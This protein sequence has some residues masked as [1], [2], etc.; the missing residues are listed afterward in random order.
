A[1]LVSLDRLREPASFGSWFC[2]I[3]LNTARRRASE[4]GRW[5][6][7][8]PAADRVA[9][10]SA[11]EEAV[12]AAELTARV[13]DAVLALPAGQRSAVTL[14]YLAGFTETEVAAE[15]GIG[16]EAV[17]SRLRKARRRLRPRLADKEEGR[18]MQTNWV[19][20]DVVD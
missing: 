9:A 13:R 18:I 12:I 16:R 1:A 8:P 3:A 17:K 2:G 14:F 11:A 5:A 10:V 19:S 7:A 4:L 6:A 15:L 20:V